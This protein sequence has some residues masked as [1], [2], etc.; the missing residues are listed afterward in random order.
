MENIINTK[1]T[2][3][4][5]AIAVLVMTVIMAGVVYATVELQPNLT[6]YPAADIRIVTNPDSSKH[7]RFSTISWNKGSGP[8]EIRAGAVDNLNGKQEVVQRIYSDDGSY[9]D[10]LAGS[11]EWHPTHGH[12]HFND[13][14]L[15]T[16]QPVGAPGASERI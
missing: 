14:A 12:V 2:A 16:L 13:Y 15:Y 6:P 3:K 7:L 8:L 1:T 5:I 11:F 4:G 9:R 10:V